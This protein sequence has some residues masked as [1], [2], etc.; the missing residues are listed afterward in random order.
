MTTKSLEIVVRW[1]I[2]KHTKAGRQ[3]HVRDP[4][5]RCFE[6]T[7]AGEA[8]AVW[9]AGWGPVLSIR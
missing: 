7:V 1:S 6:L 4:I 5:S 9:V 2:N 3:R 8:R